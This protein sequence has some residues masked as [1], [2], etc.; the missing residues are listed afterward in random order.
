M[1]TSRAT[2]KTGR[3]LSIYTPGGGEKFFQEIDAIDQ[4]DLD[5][6]VALAQRHGMSCPAPAPAV[7]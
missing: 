6:V 5:A 1:H 4:T 7:A 2:S 3:L